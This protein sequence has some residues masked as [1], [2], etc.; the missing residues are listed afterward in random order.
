MHYLNQFIKGLT[1]F[2]FIVLISL[3]YGFCIQ[4]NPIPP[5]N[6]LIWIA[7]TFLMHKTL[8]TA[9]NSKNNLHKLTGY[10]GVLIS[11]YFI[12]MVKAAYYVAY[13]NN[14]YLMESVSLIPE[15]FWD[16][17]IISI[18]NPSVFIE[19]FT[20]LLY[21]DNLSLSLSNDTI[22]SFGNGLTNTIRVIEMMGILVATF[23]WTKID[24]MRK[25][26]K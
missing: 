3:L 18:L 25:S 10:L 15:G 17:L 7:F 13:F 9:I 19:K 8:G 26:R 1:F 5:V 16:G 21:W 4:I 14:I 11:L 6:I 12:S 23:L 24:H 20:F 22:F 2:L